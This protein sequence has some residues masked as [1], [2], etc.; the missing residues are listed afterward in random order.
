MG[1]FYFLSMLLLSFITAVAKQPTIIIQVS[2]SGNIYYPQ[3]TLLQVSDTQCIDTVYHHMDMGMM[4]PGGF[5]LKQNLPDGYYELYVNDSL[6]KGGEVRNGRH[7]GD[8]IK[9]TDRDGTTCEQWHEENGIKQGYATIYTHDSLTSFSYY[10]NGRQLLYESLRYG[11]AVGRSLLFGAKS[12]NYSNNNVLAHVKTIGELVEE[13]NYQ[14]TAGKVQYYMSATQDE[15]ILMHQLG[16]ITRWRYR[17]ADPFISLELQS[18]ALVRKMQ[19][20]KTLPYLNER[21]VCMLAEE[22]AQYPGGT[23]GLTQFFKKELRYPTDARETGIEGKVY[24]SFTVNA[25]GSIIN[26]LVRRSL[27]PSCDAEAL[28]LVRSLPRFMPAK[29]NGKAVPCIMV[30]AVNFILEN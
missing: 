24:V 11:Y 2:R 7:H 17:H 20:Q 26:P 8:W 30:V 6:Y 14:D 10:L 23:Q 22:S 19:V 25:D 16:H 12:M 27:Y 3:Y 5:D 29:Q 15:L 18:P 9:W 21:Y 1:R 13:Y 28:R 4:L